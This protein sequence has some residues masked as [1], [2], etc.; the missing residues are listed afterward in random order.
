MRAA[1]QKCKSP[2]VVRP[3]IIGSAIHVMLAS[4]L[5][6]AALSPLSVKAPPRVPG[7]TTIPDVCAGLR[8]RRSAWR[9]VRT[10]R[11]LPGG[12]P[13]SPAAGVRVRLARAPSG[14]TGEVRGGAGGWARVKSGFIFPILLFSLLGTQFGGDG[15]TTFALPDLRGTE[16]APHLRYC[17]AVLVG[18]YPTRE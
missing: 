9:T 17:I 14:D 3:I 4:A 7:V 5:A 15:R 16:P 8:L 10:A 12:L 2:K 1:E 18:A 13:S 11:G 6:F